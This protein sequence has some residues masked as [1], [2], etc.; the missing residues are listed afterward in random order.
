MAFGNSKDKGTTRLS[1]VINY[2]NEANLCDYAYA[3]SKA[4]AE[5]SM[6]NKDGVIPR[7]FSVDINRKLCESLIAMNSD[8]DCDYRNINHVRKLLE[9]YRTMHGLPEDDFYAN[10]PERQ[11]DFVSYTD[12]PDDEVDVV[13][14]NPEIQP[15]KNSE[16]DANEIDSDEME[17]CILCAVEVGEEVSVKHLIEVLEGCCEEGEVLCPQDVIDCV[18]GLVAKGNF[19]VVKRDPYNGR[20]YMILRVS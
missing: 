11:P 15:V 9:N 3:V 16:Y 12:R 14:K 5:V 8:V 1:V 10:L 18:K 20:P 19:E 2:L 17:D 7:R 6:A 13:V 4:A